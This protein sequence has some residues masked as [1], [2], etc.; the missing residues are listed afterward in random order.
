MKNVIVRALS[1]TV[2]V[3]IIVAAIVTGNI[4]FFLLTA[5]LGAMGVYELQ[6]VAGL[7]HRSPLAI[8]TAALDAT[9]VILMAW[10]ALAG[11]LTTALAMTPMLMLYLLLRGLAALYDRREHPFR[12]AAWSVLSVVYLGLPMFA[13]NNLYTDHAVSKWLVLTVF[14]MI[15]LNDT[16]AFCFGSTLGRHKMFPR[17][18][19]KKSWEGFAGGFLCCLLAGAACWLWFNTAG[20]NLWQWL[21]LAVVVCL[22]STW[23]DLFESLLKRNA[24]VKDSGNIIPGHGGILDRI[25]SLLFVAP[26]VYIYILLAA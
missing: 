26:A 9:V 15:W 17:L 12:N 2:Y 24:G 4:W 8:C 13:L 5:L 23:G 22:F 11:P 3:A 18:S 14:V 10:L 16:G 1:G 21:G 7:V 25:D 6:T 20:M 19:P